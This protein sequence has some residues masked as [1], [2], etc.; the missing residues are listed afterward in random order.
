MGPTKL[1][2]WTMGYI[3]TAFCCFVL[4]QIFIMLG[5]SYPNADLFDPYTLVMV[6][7]IT[8]GWLSLLILGALPAFPISDRKIHCDW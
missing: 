2:P 6:H 1:S 5:V 3:A 4:A 7:L 8:I